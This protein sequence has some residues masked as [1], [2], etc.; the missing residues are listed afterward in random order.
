MK[1]VEMKVEKDILTIKIDLSQ[2][3]GKSSSGKNTIVA[4]TGGNQS[5]PGFPDHRIGINCYT[6]E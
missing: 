3:N 5:I 4:T 6:K 2:R 1:N